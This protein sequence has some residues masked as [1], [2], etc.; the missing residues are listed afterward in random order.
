[1]EAAASEVSPKQNDY[2]LNSPKDNT[3]LVS[4]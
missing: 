2:F 1:M 4:F 3:Y